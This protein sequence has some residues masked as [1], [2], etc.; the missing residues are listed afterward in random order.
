MI[1]NY[2]ELKPKFENGFVELISANRKEK[3]QTMEEQIAEIVSQKI[4]PLLDKKQI[5]PGKTTILA[6]KNKQLDL[7]SQAFR[8]ENIPYSQESSLP[9]F[10]QRAVAPLFFLLKFFA[11]HD[12]IELLKWFRSDVIRLSSKQLKKMMTEISESSNDISAF[13]SEQKHNPDW[14]N[15]AEIHL[16]AQSRNVRKTLLSCLEKFRIPHLFPTETD[17]KN[18]QHPVQDQIPYRQKNLRRRLV[19]GQP[20]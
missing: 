17:L 8:Q 10:Q 11:Y 4:K 18:I 7:F 14:Q 9:I 6:R 5:L 1:W 20:Y 13:F 2:D 19:A 16:I 12:L 3:E 15:L